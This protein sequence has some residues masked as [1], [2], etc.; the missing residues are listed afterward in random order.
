M[1][2]PQPAPPV[3]ATGLPPGVE[4]GGLGKRFLAQ[5]ID[6]LVPALLAAAAVYL[7][8]RVGGEIGVVIQ[9]AAA[10][11]TLAWWLLVWWGF[12]ERAAGPGMRLM[13]L[14]LVGFYDG[15]PI[16]WI[17]F[18][19]RALVLAALNVTGIGL[20]LMLIFLVMHPRKQGWH[21]LLVHAVVIKQRALAPPK[22]KV[23]AEQRRAPEA[24]TTAQQDQ[25]A[26]T[27]SN[28][29]QPHPSPQPLAPPAGV[30][31]YGPPPVPAGPQPNVA[32]PYG[33][34]SAGA[35]PAWQPTGF[36]PVPT[37]ESDQFRRP[38]P[39]GATAP[40]VPLTPPAGMAAPTEGSVEAAPS[41]GSATSP[42][43]ATNDHI[44]PGGQNGGRPGDRP[45]PTEAGS[46]SAGP[47]TRVSPSIAVPESSRADGQT[48]WYAVLDDGR[49]IDVTGLVLLGRN[50]HAQP[51]EED[52]QLIKIADETRTVSKSHL[53]IATDSDGAFVVDRGSTNGSTVTTSGGV[54]TKCRM[55]ERVRVSEGSIVSIGDHWLEIR[56]R[57]D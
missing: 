36:P 39:A 19:L 29:G 7:A 47:V 2:S 53:A 34:P 21:D 52:A 32:Q 15:R 51:G 45:P 37:P 12:A 23:A 33:E 5:L 49:E 26:G 11:L 50:P 42:A 27:P 4:V 8:P 22:S 55:G 20:L 3:N 41:A 40:P 57:T 35:G 48:G 38:Q 54:S 9:I 25:L 56:R 17:R 44:H 28:G 6:R 18:L 30:G 46:T 1:V 31:G 10:V 43:G 14:Q 16:G 13:R 24:M